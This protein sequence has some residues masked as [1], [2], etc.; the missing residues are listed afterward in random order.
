MVYVMVIMIVYRIVMGYV[1]Q[2]IVHVMMD[3][4]LMFGGRAHMRVY[5]YPICWIYVIQ[6]IQVMT[7]TAATPTIVGPDR[8]MVTVAG[9]MVRVLLRSVQLT[10]TP[11]TRMHH[12]FVIIQMRSGRMVCPTPLLMGGVIIALL[13]N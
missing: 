5:V 9:Q 8:M 2:G 4:V 10:G 7:A 3:A 11:T 13:M 1:G 6:V 12:V